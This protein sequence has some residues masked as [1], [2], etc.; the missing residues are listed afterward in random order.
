MTNIIENLSEIS[1]NYDAVFCDLWG[2]LHN[3]VEPYKEA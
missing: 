3:G 1:T 2:C